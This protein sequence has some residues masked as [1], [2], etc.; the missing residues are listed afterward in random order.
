VASFRLPH[1]LGRSRALD[2]LLTRRG[3]GASLGGMADALVAEST[4]LTRLYAEAGT[5]RGWSASSPRAGRNGTR[6]GTGSK[7]WCRR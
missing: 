4:M 7:D 5:A 6:N 2:V 1:L 3:V